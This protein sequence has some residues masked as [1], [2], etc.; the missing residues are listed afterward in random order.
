MVKKN[1]L[2]NIKKEI[3]NQRDS[4]NDLKKEKD[5]LEE[6]NKN[7]AGIIEHLSSSSPEHEDV[8]NLDPE[9]MKKLENL[10]KKFDDLKKDKADIEEK[11]KN[12]DSL[13]KTIVTQKISQT[14]PPKTEPS[15]PE[16]PGPI[17]TKKLDEMN[18][19]KE[20][21]GQQADKEKK[22]VDPSTSEITKKL[23]KVSGLE[24]KIKKLTDKLEDTPKKPA[25]SKAT[26]PAA[27]KTTA[28]AENTE[29]P[30]YQTV[31]QTMQDPVERNT[32]S[33]PSTPGFGKISHELAS[34]GEDV[35]FQTEIMEIKKSLRALNK[36]IDVINKRT[37]YKI[38]EIEDRI[39]ILK[40]VPEMEEKFDSINNKLGPDNVERLRKLVLSANELVDETIPEL[41]SKK[42]RK[43]TQPIF[44]DLRELKDYTSKLNARTTTSVEE[45]K[46]LR[47]LEDD[48]KDLKVERDRLY[49]GITDQETRFLEGIDILKHN[50]R[51]KIEG[52]TDNFS[53]QLVELKKEVFAKIT[54][55]VKSIFVN[56]AQPEFT[57]VSKSLLSLDNEI[58]KMKD[59]NKEIEKRVSEIQAPENVKTWLY[60]RMNE[61]EG[62]IMP[63][64]KALLKS[65]ISQEGFLNEL[66]DKAKDLESKYKN[67][68]NQLLSHERTMSKLLDA[69][70]L[71]SKKSERMESD[72]R[73]IFD[74]L[75]LEVKRRGS[76]NQTL[77]YMSERMVASLDDQRDYIVKNKEE[78]SRNIQNSFTALKKDFEARHREEVSRHLKE[79]ENE[80]K[81]IT[82]LEQGLDIVK[83]YSEKRLNA[84][85]KNISSLQAMP[86]QIEEIK[87]RLTDLGQILKGTVPT[88]RF[89]RSLES[90]AKQVLETQNNQTSLEKILSN[91]QTDFQ[92]QINA[93]PLTRESRKPR[94][95][96]KSR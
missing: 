45:I 2:D 87:K 4:L 12:L 48:I 42:I 30:G 7:L 19:G 5:S 14:E 10:D 55:D 71:F 16:S 9:I 61:S 46:I 72:I 36:N 79:F 83:R 35:D 85:D 44:D 89:N 69:R 27:P 67:I 17:T 33:E 26:T 50:I 21:P 29:S 65:S 47:D 54:D 15:E 75:S 77:T 96:W 25:Q 22:D 37:D 20:E 3:T 78:V 40:K 39:R 43:S 63:E 32:H 28:P 8:E 92:S 73:S 60:A 34:F 52:V 64:I 38:S 18:G 24:E 88:T 59:K 6:Q 90:L 31:S 51:K 91:T 58:K 53:L 62:K 68:P 70:E 74:K 49:K 66:S 41:V 23:E 84:A 57:S 93:M 81:R 1:E 11:N 86:P 13:M 82:G 80:I 95:F 76:L 94:M 56:V